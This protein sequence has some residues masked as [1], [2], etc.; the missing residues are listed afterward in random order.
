MSDGTWDSLSSLPPSRRRSATPPRAASG[1]AGSRTPRAL[2]S[3]YPGLP[4][5]GRSSPRILGARC[6]SREFTLSPSLTYPSRFPYD[7]KLAEAIAGEVLDDKNEESEDK[8]GILGDDILN[9]IT[10]GSD[11]DR[12]G[13]NGGSRLCPPES[14]SMAF[15]SSWPPSL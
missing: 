12:G 14:M 3:G 1:S 15:L 8:E 11:N 2:T 13:V 10:G 7:P 4:L 5:V 6:G 9:P